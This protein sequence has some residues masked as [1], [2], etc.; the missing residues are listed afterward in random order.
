MLFNLL[1][2]L[3]RIP[4]DMSSLEVITTGGAPVPPDLVRRVRDP[5]GLSLAQRFRAD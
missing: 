2:S 1:D 4:R 5:F 3:E